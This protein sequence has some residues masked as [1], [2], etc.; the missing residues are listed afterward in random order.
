MALTTA[1]L[2]PHSPLLV[3][4]IGRL[5]YSFLEKTVTAYNLIAQ[6]LKEKNVSSLVIISPHGSAS[7][8]SFTINLA[9]EVR[10]D[11]KDFGFITSNTLI[12]GD[13]SLADKIKDGLRP[14]IPIELVSE[15]VLD[16]GSA[17]PLYLLSKKIPTL[18]TVIISP[19]K[20]LTASSY[21]SF[22]KKLQEIIAT[23]DKN[24]ALIASGDLS[25]RLKKKSPGGYSPKGAKFDNK[26]IENISIGPAA[27]DNIINLDQK[28]VTAAGECGWRPLLILLGA[29]S[30]HDW[31]AE[32]LAYQ[33]D[34]GIGY[35]SA[36]FLLS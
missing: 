21:F 13:I 24:I 8:K 19:A 7:N 2:L 34:F 10:I 26:I 1:A 16:Y 18:K 12:S 9:P 32:I 5:N 11:L 4:E 33:T 6:K 29:L 22:G 30:E 15:E 25:H 20:E 28:F 14:E 35:L 36:E 3:P 17:V 27:L 23:N 31:Q